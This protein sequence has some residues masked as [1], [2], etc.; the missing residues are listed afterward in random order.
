MPFSEKIKSEVK[1]KAAYQCCVCRK[2]G[3]VEVHHII[4]QEFGGPD[5]IENAAPLCPNCHTDF[6]D[7]PKKRKAITEMR[8]WWYKKCETMFPKPDLE[9]LKNINSKLENIQEHQENVVELKEILKNFSNKTID[10]ISVDTANASASAIVRS[11]SAIRIDPV[12]YPTPLENSLYCVNEYKI[13]YCIYCGFGYK[14]V[15]NNAAYTLAL[16]PVS[17]IEIECPK[18]KQKELHKSFHDIT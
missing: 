9:I 8:D 18:C 13:H 15:N 10:M 1:E 14:V 11:V 2:I 16:S 5:T 6:G 3:T 12:V 7:N 17:G 4:P